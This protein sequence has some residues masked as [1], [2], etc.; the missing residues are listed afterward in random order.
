MLSSGRAVHCAAV[1]SES[2]HGETRGRW[3][4]IAA[5]LD[6]RQGNVA[7]VVWALAFGLCGL[8][9]AESYG[10]HAPDS[11]LASM[12]QRSVVHG[13]NASLG[14]GAPHGCPQQV[15]TAVPP[16]SATELAVLGV[17]VTVA[18][19]TGWIAPLI[20]SAGRGPTVTPAIVLTGQDLLT[21]F[22]LS[23]R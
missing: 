21:R 8:H 7:A 22:C 5:R 1:K 19:V 14:D 11:V 6:R 18:A 12:D 4:I 23:R 13:D 20:V 16:R 3:S 9:Q 15:A 17:V 2:H 10:A